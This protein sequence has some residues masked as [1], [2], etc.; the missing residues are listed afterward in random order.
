MWFKIAI[1]IWDKVAFLPT[2]F[3]LKKIHKAWIMNDTAASETPP[4]LELRLTL[5]C[6]FATKIKAKGKTER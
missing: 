4:T 3:Y 5:M 1:S 6:L 2:R